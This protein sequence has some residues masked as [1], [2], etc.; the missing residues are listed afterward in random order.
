MRLIDNL[1]ANVYFCVMLYV[2][3]L[4]FLAWATLDYGPA[5]HVMQWDH[6]VFL[7]SRRGGFIT[8]RTCEEGE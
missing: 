5:Q 6:K 3:V 1:E 8:K 4:T 2:R 7:Q